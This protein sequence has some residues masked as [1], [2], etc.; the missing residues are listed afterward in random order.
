M[1]R[2]LVFA[3]FLFL[4]E[5]TYSS[6]NTAD[7]SAEKKYEQVQ[8]EAEHQVNEGTN[9]TLLYLILLLIVP[10]IIVLV[11]F[12]ERTKNPIKNWLLSTRSCSAPKNY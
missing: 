10:A 1:R 2:V 4:L 9:D 8:Q 3:A 5:Q 6:P 11:C 7:F 12:C